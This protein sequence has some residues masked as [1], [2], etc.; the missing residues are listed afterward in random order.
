MILAEERKRDTRHRIT[1]EDREKITMTGII[2]VL[3]FDE[4]SIIADTEKGML[5][6]KGSNLHIGKLNLDDGEVCVD[7]MLESLEYNEGGISKTKD[8]FFNRLFR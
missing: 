8:S 7:G 4:E 5:L 1:L 2:D 3:S 6:L